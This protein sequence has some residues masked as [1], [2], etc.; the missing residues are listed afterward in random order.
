M[1]QGLQTAVEQAYDLAV[2]KAEMLGEGRSS[3]SVHLLQTSEGARIFKQHSPSFKRKQLALQHQAIRL[4]RKGG[5][6]MYPEVY[7]LRYGDKAGDNAEAGDGGEAGEITPESS[8][9]LSFDG[10]RYSLSEFKKGT[11]YSWDNQELR[12]TARVLAETHKILAVLST[13]YIS[14]SSGEMESYIE[15][16]C[17][18]ELR[19]LGQLKKRVQALRHEEMALAEEIEP[20]LP[21]IDAYEQLQIESLEGRSHPIFR[22]YTI[23]HG[24][25]HQKN[26]LYTDGQVNAVLDLDSIRLDRRV[27]DVAFAVHEFTSIYDHREG[28]EEPIFCRIDQDKARSFLRTYQKTFPIPRDH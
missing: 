7:N 22:D 24:D 26:V 21:A 28:F 3:G 9:L 23:I 14:M 20:L 12:D 25:F 27:Y 5:L 13:D 17:R 4:L 15:N 8:T 1:D 2:H 16:Q 19:S 6:T 11:F 10:N 18:S